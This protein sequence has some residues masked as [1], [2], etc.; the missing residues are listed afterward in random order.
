LGP[1]F[2][3]LTPEYRE[4]QL[5]QIFLLMYY[6]GFSYTEAQKLPLPYRKWFI[7][8]IG[9]EFKKAAEANGNASR[10][11]HDNTAEMRALQGRS[12]TNVPAK[13]TRFT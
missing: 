12:R 9:K 3:G 4:L 6:G 5:D 11:P 2:F 1:S 7:E 10:A 8:R 13:M